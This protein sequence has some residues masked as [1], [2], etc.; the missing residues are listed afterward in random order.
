MNHPAILLAAAATAV[1]VGCSR[2]D[3]KAETVAPPEPNP[4]TFTAGD[5]SY[6]GPDTIPAGVTTFSLVNQGNEAHHI[7]LL[8]LNDGKTVEDFMALKPEKWP[9]WVVAV[10]GP[11]AAMPGGTVAA[12]MNVDAGNYVMLCLIPSSDGTPHI[13]KG[14][15]RPLTVVAASGPTAAEP[16]ADLTLNLV[17]Y[18]FNFSAPLTAGRHTIRLENPTAQIH[19]VLIV[20]LE[21]GKK[22]EDFLAWTEKMGGPPPGVP[23]NGIGGMAPGTRAYITNDFTPGN[24]GLICFVP[25]AG[26]GKP[27]FMHGMIQ[28]ITIT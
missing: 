23:V 1:L 6:A 21:P 28:Q 3:Q 16:E 18:A 9:A 10:G 12:T 4:I 5:Y 19:E 26:D 7:F 15:V 17:D 13:A 2:P 24:Y 20:R 27:H 11:N 14:M 25:D 22:V 8:K